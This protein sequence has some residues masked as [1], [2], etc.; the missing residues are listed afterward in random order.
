[1]T[2][3]RAEFAAR[4]DDVER[5]GPSVEFLDTLN[6]DIPRLGSYGSIFTQV[7]NVSTPALDAVEKMMLIFQKPRRSHYAQGFL[8]PFVIVY[9][10]FINTPA[11]SSTTCD[12]V[13]FLLDPTFLE[14]DVFCAA[15]TILTFLIDA[16][17]FPEMGQ[18]DLLY[19]R[20]LEMLDPDLNA[21]LRLVDK[22]M[23]FVGL[24]RSFFS[25]P[26]SSTDSI[27]DLWTR[28]LPFWDDPDLLLKL[29]IEK[30]V[31]RKEKV[32]AKGNEAPEIPDTAPVG[33]MR[34]IRKVRQE[35]VPNWPVGFEGFVVEALPLLNKFLEKMWAADGVPATDIAK[36]LIMV[37]EMVDALEKMEQS[38]PL[39]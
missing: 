27:L 32:I 1:L 14:A 24:M 6:V 19:D 34:V 11:P 8:V 29:L 36:A 38:R 23:Y 28:L 18:E 5:E 30:I 7:D 22:S 25:E 26:Y 4:R 12:D 37:G 3:K 10:L 9:Y 31:R 21:A 13:L 15:S 17:C 33:L 16:G 2:R 35:Q 20:F 39:E